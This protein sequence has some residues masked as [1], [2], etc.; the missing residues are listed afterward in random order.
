MDETD[1]T[2]LRILDAAGE[3]F[4]A[5]GFEDATVRDICQR[6]GANIAA[7][8]YH[9]GDKQRLYVAAVKRAHAW[10]V[11]QAKM[12]FWPPGT[13]AEVRLQDFIRT[14]L[15]RMVIGDATWHSRLM[16]REMLRP[17]SACVELVREYIRPEFDALL[18]ILRELL[19]SAIPESKLHL[20][21]FSIVG[22]C[23]HYRVADPIVKNLVDSEEY[24]SY[25]PEFLAEHVIE[26]SMSALRQ[27]R[28]QLPRAQTE[29]SS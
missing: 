23:L 21:A 10:R 14:F 29:V 20:L 24:A 13:L 18:A 17:D 2:P 11:E 22:Q 16:L 19:R 12:P 1:S 9:F 3:E 25:T 8:N 26:F 4:A 28:D 7:V 15:R 6:A 27:I 5:K